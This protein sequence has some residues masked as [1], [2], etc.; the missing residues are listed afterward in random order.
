MNI[1]IA[2]CRYYPEI[3][4]AP[5]RITN[6]AKSL[7]C[8]GHQV[9]VLTCL[10]CYPQNKKF[11][12]YRHCFTRKEAIDGITIFRYWANASVST[13]PIVRAISMFSFAITLWMFAIHINR[14]KKYDVVVI[15]TPTIASAASAMH[16]FKGLFKKKVILNV[17]DLWPLTGVA[18]GAMHEGQVSYKYMAHLENYLYRSSDGIIGQSQEILDYVKAKQPEKQL[19]LY[20]NLQLTGTRKHHSLQRH[21]PLK[22]VYAGLFGVPQGILSLIKSV[23]FKQLGVEMHLYGGGC[24]TQD[25]KKYIESGDY[26]VFYHGFVSK[27]EINELLPKYDVSIVPLSVSILGAVPSKLYDLMPLGVPTIFCGGGEGADIV[28]QNRIGLVSTPGDYTELREKI[29]SFRDMSDDEYSGYVS[30]CISVSRDMFSY[31]V[32]LEKLIGFI[33]RFV[34]IY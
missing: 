31:D 32:Q 5:V 2:S 14:I 24:Q 21:K 11:E 17:S 7:K 29:Q 20:R 34:T 16:L 15:Q 12:G 13:N 3:G 18:L 27:D 10:P 26:N 33:E 22:I 6:M 25:I 28:L 9:D 19:F 30:R 4:A 8:M 23:D 1:L